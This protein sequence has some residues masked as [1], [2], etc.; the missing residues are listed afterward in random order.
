MKTLC[1]IPARLASTRLPRKMLALIQGQ[2]M[3][4]RT[5]LNA[6][7]CADF[8]RCVVATDSQEIADVIEAVGGEVIM[9]SAELETGSDRVAFVAKQ[10][11]DMEVVV[12]LQGDEPFITPNILSALLSPYHHGLSPDMATIAYPILSEEEYRNPNVVKVICDQAN[13]A[14]YFSRSP[15]PYYRDMPDTHPALHHVGLYAYKHSVLQTFSQLEQTP[16]EKVEKLEQL[17]ALENGTKIYVTAINQ[18]TLEINTP[19]EL[20]SAQGFAGQ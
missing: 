16:L 3:I 6:R 9:T 13:Y 12:N 15:I 8:S 7:E 14:L 17:R 5:Y 4:Q 10:Y 11:S 18:R 19:E 1:V 2:P 20:E